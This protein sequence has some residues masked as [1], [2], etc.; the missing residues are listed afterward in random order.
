MILSPH[1]DDAVLSCG[2]LIADTHRHGVDSLVITVFNGRPTLPVSS[3]AKRFHAR[4]GLADDHAMAQRECE[5]D[6]ALDIVGASTRRL[7]LLEALYRKGSDGEPRYDTDQAIFQ[8]P[9]QPIEEEVAAVAER[10]AA[11]VAVAD[12][13]L[14]LA[15]LGIGGHIDHLLVSQ[16]ARQLDRNV[17]HYEDVPYVLYER[18]Q[19]WWVDLAV[20]RPQLYVC[21][22][23]G[24]SAKIHAIDCYTSQQTVLWYSPSTWRRDLTSFACA[25]GH[26][27]PAERYWMLGDR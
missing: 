2:G 18:C 10:I 24:W 27:E 1:L 26:G 15:P 3:P 17:L 23:N 9:A 14:V 22:R 5:D 16:A 21:T 7:D 11:Q 13:D 6:E 4:C 25:I 12:P 20:H 19:R 8:P